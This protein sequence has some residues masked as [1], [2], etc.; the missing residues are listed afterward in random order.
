MYD[1]DVGQR[2]VFNGIE[3][4]DHTGRVY[5]NADNRGVMVGAGH[6]DC[7][8]AASESDVDDDRT[9][10]KQRGPVQRRSVLGESPACDPGFKF[11]L[12]LVTQRSSTR[13]E[14]R[15]RP[16]DDALRPLS[17]IDSAHAIEPIDLRCRGCGD[18]RTTPSPP[19]TLM[20]LL[21]CLHQAT[22]MQSEH[23]LIVRSP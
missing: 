12:A 9:V 1:T 21:T 15:V 14:R 17:S 20:L 3:H 13:L 18:H 6:V 16:L 5:L 7:A 19:A 8:L 2:V 22:E 10:S 4:C 23:D 11:G